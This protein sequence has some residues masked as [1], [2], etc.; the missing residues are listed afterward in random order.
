MTDRL[1]P[2]GYGLLATFA[3]CASLAADPDALYFKDCD[4]CPELVRIEPGAF[5]MGSPE[6]EVIPPEYPKERIEKE[7]PARSVRIQYPFAI[8]RYEVTIGEFSAFADATDFTAEGCFGLTGEQ[9]E[10][11]PNASWRAP[12]FEVSDASAATCLSYDDFAA[13]LEWL[14]RESGHS[15]RFPTEAEWEFVARSGLGDQPA[16]FSLGKQ[17]CQHLNGADTR[18]S[19]QFAVDWAPGL[20]DCDDGAAAG[21]AV[22]SY[23]SNALGMFD[24][25]GNMS[26][27]TADCAGADHEGAPADGSA[28]RLEPCPA[29]VLKGGS[30][31][32]GPGYLRPATRASFPSPLRG[33]GHGL[34]V[35]RELSD[36]R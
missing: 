7:R 11:N 9:W 23:Q 8:G 16:P 10:L 26:E 29:R 17:A 6:D 14:S 19:K 28:R 27:W 21:S 33:D 13:Y 24:V 2:C 4:A 1:R 34:R 36:L 35:V 20:F 22:G 5:Q 31:S 18:F 25:F 12:G 32:G 30:W 3:A 15:Y